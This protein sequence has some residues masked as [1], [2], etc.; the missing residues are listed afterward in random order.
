MAI[1]SQTDAI[2]F[3]DSA[4]VVNPIKL[5]WLNDWKSQGYKGIKNIDLWIQVASLL[6]LSNAKV[7][8][9]PRKLNS[10]ADKFSK[11]AREGVYGYRAVIHF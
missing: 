1:N 7:E 5:K 2:I 4:Y 11:L 9:I 10:E 8:Q 6:E 3:T